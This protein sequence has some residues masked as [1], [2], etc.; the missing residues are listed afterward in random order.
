MSAESPRARPG[1]QGGAANGPGGGAPR[2]VES[3]L[4]DRLKGYFDG[5][6]RTPTPDHLLRL[7]DALEAALERGEL[8]R[9]ARRS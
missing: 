6:S 5:L 8:K 7:T 9:T 4:G 3:S 1:L 2:R